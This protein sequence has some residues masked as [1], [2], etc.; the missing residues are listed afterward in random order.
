M[1]SV[2]KNT[3]LLFNQAGNSVGNGDYMVRPRINALFT[4]A[5]KNSVIVVCAGAGY[6]KTRAVSDFLQHQERPSFWV[7][8]NERDNSPT[9]FWENF[10]NVVLQFDELLVEKYR[11]IGFPDTQEKM[12][13]FHKLRKDEFNKPAIIVFD[14]FH[15]L[16]EPSVIY[17]MEKMINEM[18]SNGTI[19]LICRDLA[20]ININN[21][22]MKG[23]ISEIHE[24]DLSF[25]ESE[26]IEY[27]KKQKFSID[28]HTIHEIY[29]DT[30]GWT[31]AINLVA[32]SLKRMPNYF[33]YVKNTLKQNIFK[34]L[35]SE[36]WDT[37]T[38]CLKN[39]L[40]KLSLIDHLSVEL[41]E[42]LADNDD[43]LLSGLKKQN[44]Y[45]R[46]DNYGGTY[47]IH[48]LFLDFLRT[49]H[50][51]LTDDEKYE[52]YKAAANWCMQNNFKID[53]LGYFEKIGDYGSILSVLHTFPPVFP[54]DMAQYAKGL[55][56]RAPSEAFD[57]VL[58][59]ATTHMTAVACTGDFKEYFTLADFYE[60]KFLA[61]PEGDPMRNYTLFGLYYSLGIT[62]A[63]NITDEIYDF[64]AYFAKMFSCV[65]QESLKSLP[66]GDVPLGPWIN[67]TYSALKGAP[68]KYVEAMIR[69]EKLTAP[70]YNGLTS[71]KDDLIQGELLFYQ[72]DAGAAEPFVVS[73]MENA[74]KREA[75]QTLHRA[76]FYM[77]RIAFAEGNLKKAKAAII[78]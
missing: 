25:S 5:I 22:Q 57:S 24:T 74:K 67:L 8:F 73:A 30:K 44:A 27:I 56:D 20:N 61:L 50:D 65:T 48:H 18:P 40:V 21:L 14:D 47:L 46:L 10:T 58:F 9:R 53:A 72:G 12:D 75:Y 11:E 43:V 13:R 71:G 45:I 52:A 78:E 39:F 23:Y 59:L 33:G 29:K 6:G 63:A 37:I 4:N 19:I 41:V 16:N 38:E 51:I 31:F 3:E 64:D 54:Y 2:S 7:Q 66:S 17:F 15:L 26:L 55:F 1:K 70:Y 60:R 49:K 69:L 77:M 42:T 76:L 68:Q 36:S 62:R 34:L 28:S 35:E 32:R